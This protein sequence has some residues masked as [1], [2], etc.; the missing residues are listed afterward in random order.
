MRLIAAF[1]LPLVI[2][3]MIP[4]VAAQSTN[5]TVSGIVL[6]PSGKLIPGADIEIVNDATGVRYPGTTNSEGIY[7]VTSLPPGSYRVQVSKIGFKTLIKP[8]II[9]NTQDALAINFT[10]PVGA[11]SETVTV[12]GGSSLINT[13]SATVST[14]VNRQFAENLPMNGRS[15]QSLIE[16]TPGVVVTPSSAYDGG[17]F[18]V[19]GQRAAANYWMVDGVGANIGV[20]AG[21]IPGNGFGGTLGS[22][23]AL[24]GTN[25]LVSVD[26][27]QEF[28]IQ[29]STFAPEFGRTPGGQISI[30]TRSGTNR[31]HGTLFDYLR[32]DAFDASNW[33]NGY[34]NNPPLPKAEERQNDFGGTFSGPIRTDE[35][36]FFLSYEGLRLRLPQTTLTTVPD[37]TAR[38]NAVAAMQ[39][40]L[41]A[42]PLPNGTD[43][44]AN[45]A[46]Q[47]NASF[48]NPA[49]LDAI[50]LRMD[51]KL[52]RRWSFF[53]RYNYSPSEFV[54]RGGIGGT[55]ALSTVVPFD[56]KTETATAGATWA[57]SIAL[58]NDLRFN[59]SR[60]SSKSH[61]YM[62]DFGGAAPLTNFPFPGPLTDQTAL[63]AMSIF[64]LT[65]GT[66][67]QAGPQARNIQRQINLVDN[68]SWQKGVHGL[69]IGVDYRRL[70]PI[71]AP[72]AYEQLA[73]FANVPMAGAGQSSAADVFSFNAVNLLFRNLGVFAQ[74]TWRMSPRATLT[75]GLRWDVDFAPSAL[76]GPNIPAV[77][78]Y[79]LTNFANL[80][81]AP[82]GTEP[83]VT[84]FGNVAPRIGLAYQ[85]SRSQ[86]W[87]TVLRTGIGIFYDLASSQ[88][89]NLVGLQAPP[90]AALNV[91][92]SPTFPLTPSQITAPLIPP[93]GSLSRLVAFN[94]HL[95]LPYTLEWN[96]A[97]EQSI[98]NDQSL[99]LTY[100]GAFGQRLIQST[101]VSSPPTNP[102]IETGDFID[103]TASSNYNALQL[104]FRRR[105]SYGLQALASYT[106]AHSI[107]NASAGSVGSFSNY[108]TPGMN[109]NRGDSDFDI[110]NALTF[111][112]TYDVPAVHANRV[113][114]AMLHG[115]SIE[116]FLLARSATPVDLDDVDFYEFQ[117]NVEAN[118]RP[119]I[120]PGHPFYLYGPAYPGGKA[121]NAAAFTDPPIDPSTGYPLRQGN[122]GRNVLRGFGATQWDFA[123]HR[124]FPV[125]D[126]VKLQFRA[127]MF[128]VLNRP[129]FGPPNNQFGEGGFGLSSQ[130]L[131]QSLSNGSLGSGGF[132]P[133]YQIG[134]PRSIQFALKLTF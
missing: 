82:A 89:G 105:L 14:V 134:G 30:V 73:Y 43:D 47:F 59:Y 9:L 112:E 120:V 75:Y 85:L 69:K 46:A 55:D 127:E 111:G 66:S 45:G 95:E 84:T 74:D 50:S 88:A 109:A 104:Q 119:D 80:A 41:N 36:F 117:G 42:F 121:L 129:N 114:D 4:F 130:T 51:D 99:S 67:L 116:T 57:A 53:G 77:T 34:K 13:E 33:F 122:L 91:F 79:S 128:N 106:W 126:S 48:S 54:D 107:D 23:S 125:H 7:V 15:F 132:D 133:L 25:S 124:E 3:C 56:I 97:L 22:F 90:F 24:G 103:N 5:G 96:A 86:G 93:T 62:D 35:V 1:C 28:R 61:S 71:S 49:S 131:S 10:L 11:A 58:A 31:F 64:G 52:T 2:L 102:A 72:P 108:G 32:N 83:F 76:N 98:G 18:S 87:G 81:I 8:D 65:Q 6:D 21:N 68:L 94:P 37:L 12:E 100:L 113:T 60:A 26:A 92:F 27:M 101:A 63:F 110:R 20:A 115:W 40:Y 29:T 70:S 17:Q 118:V 123:V 38:Q 16:L 44:P 19:N 39:P 78:G